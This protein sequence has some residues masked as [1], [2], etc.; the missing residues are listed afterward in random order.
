LPQRRLLAVID[1]ERK[2]SGPVWLRG[3]NSGDN[4]DGFSE[5]NCNAI[6]LLAILPVSMWIVCHQLWL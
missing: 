4:D 6:G 1:R 3:R 2:K 5:L